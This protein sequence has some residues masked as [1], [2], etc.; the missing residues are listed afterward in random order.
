MAYCEFCGDL[1]PTLPFK[2]RYCGGTY[3]KKH[4]LPENHEC[5]FDLKISP[6]VPEPRRETRPMYHDVRTK[7]VPLRG[8]E[9][10]R[11]KEIQ[12]YLKRQQ[13]QR[14]SAEQGFFR[15][16]GV[17]GTTTGT[18][19]IILMIVIFSIA[20]YIL[21]FYSLQY[22]TAFSLTGLYLLFL[23][24]IFT[25]AFVSYTGDL[26]GLLFV[27][28]LIFFYYNISRNLELRF[29]TK[30]LVSLYFFCAS[31]TAVFYILIRILLIPLYPIGVVVPIGLATGCLLGLISFMIYFNP[32]QEMVLF[33]YFIPVKMKGRLLLAILI[34]FRLI[35]GLLFG[36]FE[37]TYLA[38]YIPDLGGILASYIVF[39][40]KFKHR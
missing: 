10:R 17:G 34:L 20:T 5:T 9:A 23:W 29:G 7:S 8:S 26:F 39:V 40:Y 38:L 1:I 21:T 6:V 12:R 11:Q 33:C 4:R 2:C 35:P 30:F 3:C 14:K 25:G 19:F 37:P 27:F 15:S 31:I 32:D 22:L 16:M 36:L 18:T 28:I 24:V 13:K